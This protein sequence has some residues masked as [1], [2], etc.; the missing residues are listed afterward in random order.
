MEQSGYVSDV[1]VYVHIMNGLCNNGQLEN[2]V[3]IM[4]DCLKK[5]F[6]LTRLICAKLINKLLDSNKVE[7]AYKLF[8]KVKK[9]VMMKMHG[10]IGELKGGT[11]EISQIFAIQQ[12]A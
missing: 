7:M 10:N 2:A 5:G 12:R 6:C 3:V 4:E 1:E 8:L 11:F 9:V